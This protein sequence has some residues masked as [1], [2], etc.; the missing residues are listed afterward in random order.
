MTTTPAASYVHGYTDLETR[1]LSDQADTLSTLLHGGTSYPAGARVLEV[2]CGVGGQTV[3]LVAA[4]PGAHIVA[5]DISAES[6][7]RARARVAASVPE[8]N[9]EWH[10][11]D[12]HDLPF[13]DESFDHLF[14][15]FVL[16]HV[17][18]PE[19]VLADL[20]RLLRPGGTVTVIEGDHATAVFHPDSAAAHAAIDCLVT[21]Q[22]AA[23]GDAL[24][25]R[26]LQPLLAGAGY[27]EVEVGTRTVYVDMTRPELVDGF[28]RNTFIAMVES[29]RGEVLATGLITR[30]DWERGIADLARTADDGGTFHYTFFRGT[31]V[32]GPAVQAPAG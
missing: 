17:R 4:S 13:P 7:A 15:C 23:G 10:H 16:E 12:L 26:R 24:I 2:G 22:A 30:D 27:A 6:L 18:D 3:H 14:L 32:W 28:T 9:V 31:A 1:R 5:V 20:G 29:V 19:R 11:A 21:L 25:G 8:A